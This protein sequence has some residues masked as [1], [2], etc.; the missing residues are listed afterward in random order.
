MP[1]RGRE[2]RRIDLVAEATHAELGGVQPA[3]ACGIGSSPLAPQSCSRHVEYCGGR[4][5][6]SVSSPD[7]ADQKEGGE[8]T[9]RKRHPS[10]PAADMTW[11]IVAGYVYASPRASSTG[12]EPSRSTRRQPSK[13]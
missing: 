10:R 12:A 6:R 13:T 5:L 7:G 8:V 3:R 2:S 4:R 1:R 11:G 9:T